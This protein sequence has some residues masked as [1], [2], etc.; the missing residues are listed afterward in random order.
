MLVIELKN[1]SIQIWLI[2]VPNGPNDNRPV[3]VQVKAWR[4]T[5]ATPLHVLTI[6]QLTN[7]YLRHFATM[8]LHVR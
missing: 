6:A 3:L 8:S 4:R 5:G 2:F 7:A 1:I